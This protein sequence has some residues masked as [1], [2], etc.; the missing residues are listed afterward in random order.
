MVAGGA[1]RLDPALTMEVDLAPLD[2]GME[3]KHGATRRSGRFVPGRG[4]GAAAFRARHLDVL[5]GQKMGW[6][7]G[8]SS[9]RQ[10]R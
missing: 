8:L 2:P 9:T 6:R 3:E 7:V 5:P 1:Q 10:S 4:Q